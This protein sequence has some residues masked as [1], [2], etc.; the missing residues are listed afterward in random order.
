[1]Q[2]GEADRLPEPAEPS[3][4]YPAAD[5]H[6]PQHDHHYGHPVNPSVVAPGRHSKE[7]RADYCAGRKVSFKE[8]WFLSANAPEQNPVSFFRTVLIRAQE[9]EKCGSV[10]RVSDFL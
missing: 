2:V 7:E 4:A 5:G 6:Y 10:E 8:G 1:M 9:L 3:V